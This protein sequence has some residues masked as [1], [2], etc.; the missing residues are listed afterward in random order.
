M[1]A[2]AF[3]RMLSFI[4]YLY[5]GCTSQTSRTCFL[6]Y[7]SIHTM[8]YNVCYYFLVSMGCYSRLLHPEFFISSVSLSFIFVLHEVIYAVLS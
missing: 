4:F 1:T 6:F 5:L 8:F 3:L 2:L 7:F